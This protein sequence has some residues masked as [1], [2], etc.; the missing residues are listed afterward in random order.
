MELIKCRGS[1]Q[2]VF[3]FFFSSGGAYPYR[4]AEAPGPEPPPIPLVCAGIPLIFL[5]Y[6]QGRHL[7]LFASKYSH[8]SILSLFFSCLSS[9]FSSLI[10]HFACMNAA[11]LVLQAQLPRLADL[12]VRHRS[13][14]N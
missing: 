7:P 2:L 5:R 11:D 10:S 3:F 14:P 8:G 12:A 6:S 1:D 9:S 13:P 4:N